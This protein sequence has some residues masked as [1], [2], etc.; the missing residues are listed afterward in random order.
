MGADTNL[1]KGEVSDSAEQQK[2]DVQQFLANFLRELV[3]EQYSDSDQPDGEV[4]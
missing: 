1:L 4:R 3:A 2:V